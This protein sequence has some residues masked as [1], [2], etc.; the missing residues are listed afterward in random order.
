MLI[1]NYEKLTEREQVLFSDKSI[2]I[3]EWLI[4]ELIPSSENYIETTVVTAALFV[5]ITS[6]QQQMRFREK[7]STLRR[8]F[9]CYDRQDNH[10]PLQSV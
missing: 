5:F 8:F 4:P 10:S 9:V 7:I 3:E 6:D 2:L 1:V